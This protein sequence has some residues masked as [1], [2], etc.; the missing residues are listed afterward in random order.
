[1]DEPETVVAVDKTTR[2]HESRGRSATTGEVRR[3]SAAFEE[4]G[5][6]WRRFNWWSATEE[7]LAGGRSRA[8]ER[9]R[10]EFGFFFNLGIRARFK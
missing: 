1:M 5:R 10:R 9:E 7:E 4:D 3:R 6:R 2:T 8:A